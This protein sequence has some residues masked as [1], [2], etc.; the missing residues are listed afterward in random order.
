M[1]LPSSSTMSMVA[2]A[3]APSKLSWSCI[4]LP[5]SSS[6]VLRPS[7][8][9][10]TPLGV[11]S[12]KNSLSRNL[13]V[14]NASA[15]FTAFFF[16]LPF[17]LG[18][19]S[20][21]SSPSP[22]SSPNSSSE[23]PSSLSSS[24]ACRSGL[25]RRLATI[26]C[27][28]SFAFWMKLS[29]CLRLAAIVGFNLAAV[30]SRL[31]PLAALAMSASK[32]VAT[33]L[34]ARI[35]CAISASPAASSCA[36]SLS[37]A[38]IVGDGP[39]DSMSSKP[40]ATLSFAALPRVRWYSL[41]ALSQ[42]LRKPSS[43]VLASN[44]SRTLS[45]TRSSDV[46]GMIPT[47]LRCASSASSAICLASS[48]L[49]GGLTGAATSDRPRK[50]CRSTRNPISSFTSSECAT[51]VLPARATRPT[52]CTNSFGLGGKSK[53]TTLSSSGMSMPRAATSVTTITLVFLFRNLPMWS[54]R[55]AMSIEPYTAETVMPSDSSTVT[56]SSTWCLVAVNTTVCWLSGTTS[57]RKNRSEGIFSSCRITVKESFRSGDTFISASSLMTCGSFKPTLTNSAS[58]E[59]IVAEKSRH[60]RW[61]ATCFMMSLS[62]SAKPISRSRSASSSTTCDTL[63]MENP[64][65]SS[66]WWSKRPGVATKRSGFDARSSNCAS[67]ESPP[68]THTH[69]RSVN[70]ESSCANL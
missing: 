32:T 67:M 44:S 18:F 35:C 14:S 9:W 6:I 56:S 10:F 69:R 59:G 62:W 21:S 31:W 49:S 7:S 19:F 60:C 3:S 17:P 20:A 30:A 36:S 8:V 51:P 43:S 39:M 12:R 34:Y 4:G 58:A 2:S 28:S 22:S 25:R 41:Y 40:L 57:L 68:T 52:R 65:I 23:S 42:A 45:C 38:H 63:R 15:T 64:L 11:T 24:S 47:T 33:G 66:T 50:R 61:S 46:G 53:L 1:P 54:L 27:P 5:R 37:A 48:L 29:C 13:P 16:F 70:L 26:P 55:A